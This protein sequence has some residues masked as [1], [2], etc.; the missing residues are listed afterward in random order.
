MSVTRSP[1]DVT[2]EGRLL[3][4]ERTV[5][6]GVPLVGVINWMTELARK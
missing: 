5:S 4:L 1:F 2:A 6:Q 3:V